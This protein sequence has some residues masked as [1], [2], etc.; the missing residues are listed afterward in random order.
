MEETKA[1]YQSRTIIGALVQLL[2]VAAATVGIS[3]APELQGEITTWLLAAG[4]LVG[5]ALTIYGRIKATKG[6]GGGTATVAKLAVALLLLGALSIGGPVACAS[7]EA[8][9]AEK[10]SPAQTIFAL[11]ADYNTAAMVAVGYLESGY[12]TPAAKAAIARLDQTAFS[13]IAGAANAVRSGDG[14]AIAL[15]T[16]AARAA[17][18]ELLAYVE[19]RKRDDPGTAPGPPSGQPGAASKPGAGT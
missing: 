13:T 17:V 19:A 7:Y 15:S 14:L 12:A 16:A 5:G 6:I 3:V 1:W 4:G 8:S 9:K 2:C 18:A 11:Q 10:L